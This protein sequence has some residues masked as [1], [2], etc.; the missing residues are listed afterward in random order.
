MRGYPAGRASHTPPKCRFF[1][2]F[3]LV[4]RVGGLRASKKAEVG[5]KRPGAE[6][7]ASPHR[8]LAA[9]TAR[10]HTSIGCR[11]RSHRNLMISQSD[12]IHTTGAGGVMPHGRCRGVRWEEAPPSPEG[13]DGITHPQ[14]GARGPSCAAISP[15]PV[16]RVSRGQ[17]I[18]GFVAA[19]LHPMLVC[20]RAVGAAMGRCERDSLPQLRRPSSSKLSPENPLHR[21]RHLRLADAAPISESIIS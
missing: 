12:E 19:L 14:A 9:P 4:R 15:A 17:W 2:P 10:P 18:I 11:E 5:R 1:K 3:R 13:V 20:C 6:E 21:R 7:E 8:D 16:V